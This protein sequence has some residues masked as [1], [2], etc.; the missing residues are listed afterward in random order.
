MNELK[1]KK[2]IIKKHVLPK[3]SNFQIKVRNTSPLHAEITKYRENK[4]D[5]IICG[6]IKPAYPNLK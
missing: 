2:D 3:E 5:T 6:I 4:K 1:S